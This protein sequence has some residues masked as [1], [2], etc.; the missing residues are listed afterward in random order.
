MICKYCGSVLSQSGEHTDNFVRSWVE[1]GVTKR[2]QMY[3]VWSSMKTRCNNPNHNSYKY[4]GARGFKICDEWKDYTI[5]RQWMID[6]GFKPGLKVDRIDNDQGYFPANC[7]LATDQQQV[8][9]RRLPTRSRT[10]KRYN[11][12]ILTED[13]IYAIRDSKLTNIALSRVY[14]VH[15][16]TISNIK[17]RKSWNHLPEKN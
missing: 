15:N 13:D 1:N 16:S 4:Y 8:Q 12:R 14:D 2:P 11:R 10:G 5:F 17:K 6:Q 3:R 9:N 7:Q